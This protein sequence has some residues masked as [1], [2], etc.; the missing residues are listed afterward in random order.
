M[1]NELTVN[2]LTGDYPGTKTF[3]SRCRGE[4]M[5]VLARVD[6]E[7]TSNYDFYNKKPITVKFDAVDKKFYRE[8]EEN[9]AMTKKVVAELISARPAFPYWY[10][11][12]KNSEG[13]F[14][15]VIWTGPKPDYGVD[16]HDAACRLML[17]RVHMP[18][19]SD[20]PVFVSVVR[21]YGGTVYTH[22]TKKA[23]GESKG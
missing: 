2:I 16:G 10:V 14:A 11:V 7:S 17:E 1:S 3:Y 6:Y 5:D 4:G 22:Y 8:I 21:E 12:E 19:E 13:G 15:T 9:G 23:E 20:K 18:R